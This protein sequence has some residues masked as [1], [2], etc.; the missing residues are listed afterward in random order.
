MKLQWPEE[1]NIVLDLVEDIIYVSFDS[2]EIWIKNF[3]N[4]NSTGLGGLQAVALFFAI[5]I[6]IIVVTFIIGFIILFG[7]KVFAGKAIFGGLLG[8]LGLGCDHGGKIYDSP[9]LPFNPHDHTGYSSYP[10]PDAHSYTGPEAF[11]PSTAYHHHHSGSESYGS[12]SSFPSPP[13]PDLPG[14]YKNNEHDHD[15]S[16]D[17]SQNPISVTSASASPHP[18]RR[19][20]KQKRDAGNE[21]VY[22]EIIFRRLNF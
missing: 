12:D 19:V 4:F 15:P 2:S 21:W 13:Y 5:K 14:I 1:E 3:I 9:V 22:H 8:N 17:L 18:Y 7:I 20:S 16:A 11:D 10:G 6:K